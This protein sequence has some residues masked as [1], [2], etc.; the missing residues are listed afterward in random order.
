[1]SQEHI[2]R[3]NWLLHANMQA[4]AHRQLFR[5]DREEEEVLMMRHPLAERKACA[6]FGLMLGTLPAAAIFGRMFQ[7]GLVGRNRDWKLFGL[8]LVMNIICA[9]V[10]YAMGSALSG[11]MHNLTRTSWNKTLLLS[12]LVGALWGVIAGG[13]G[14]F[15]FFGFG[16]VVGAA[17]AIPVGMAAFLLFALLHRPLAR[18]GMIDARHFWPL[19]CGITLTIAALVLSL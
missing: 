2:A 1:L 16:A 3:L 13:A 10:G 5:N 14:G 6:I 18:G 17:C 4:A 9:V 7:Y 8:C 12:P 11:S 15:I 19:A